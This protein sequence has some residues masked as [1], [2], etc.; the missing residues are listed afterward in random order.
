MCHCCDYIHFLFDFNTL[1]V[2][3]SVYVKDAAHIPFL[4]DI[5]GDVQVMEDGA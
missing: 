5:H 1:S 2:A 3:E 4:L